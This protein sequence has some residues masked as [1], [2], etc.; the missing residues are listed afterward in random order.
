MLAALSELVN[1]NSSPRSKQHW[2]HHHEAHQELLDQV[3]L[4]YARL[5]CGFRNLSVA[6]RH[7]A[8]YRETGL[9][10]GEGGCGALA[11]P[12]LFDL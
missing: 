4:R 7:L 3:N 8:L 9:Q 1:L 2:I 5:H 6:L 11:V 12:L 10:E